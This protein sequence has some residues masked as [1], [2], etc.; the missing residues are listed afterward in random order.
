MDTFTK[1][2]ESLSM[3]SGD[4]RLRKVRSESPMAENRNMTWIMRRLTGKSRKSL[5][6][7][8]QQG[9][10]ILNE[11]YERYIG[12]PDYYNQKVAECS[13]CSHN[14]TSRSILSNDSLTARLNLASSDVLPS[15]PVRTAQINQ[16]GDNGLR[17]REAQNEQR[18]NEQ[19]KARN[20]TL[21][22][23]DETQLS[24]NEKII[25]RSVE[26]V[27]GWLRELPPTYHPIHDIMRPF[28]NEKRV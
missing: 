20:C 21:M 5:P 13:S 7:T 6:N 24:E 14:S 25:R 18:R 4:K 3:S 27:D 2:K 19:I 26:K 28:L 16:G 8:N 22:H 12:V 9:E 1:L 10:V 11:G 15:I 23:K 17:K